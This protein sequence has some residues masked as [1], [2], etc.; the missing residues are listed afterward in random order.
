MIKK[1]ILIILL[2]QSCSLIELD[3]NRNIFTALLNKSDIS[4]ID[5]E[6]LQSQDSSY[7]VLQY[8]NSQMVLFLS[9]IDQNSYEY[10]IGPNF[11]RVVLQ[12]GIIIEVS[13]FQNNFKIRGLVNND[14]NSKLSFDLSNPLLIGAD[15]ILSD[16]KST[17]TKACPKKQIII[18]EIPVLKKKYNDFLC[19]NDNNLLIKTKQR[20]DPL[21]KPIILNIFYRY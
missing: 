11:E 7:M 20:I 8:E 16:G 19:F 18:R 14:Y 21:S 9:S 17:K 6:Y 12:K 4:L 2:L 1:N 13:G 5:K 15:L 3:P 10:W